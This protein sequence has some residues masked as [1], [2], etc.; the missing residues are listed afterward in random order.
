MSDKGRSRS[1]SQRCQHPRRH[2]RL[3]ARSGSSLY[4]ANLSLRELIF[5]LLGAGPLDLVVQG[6]ALERSS[7]LDAVDLPVPPVIV[8]VPSNG[9]DGESLP[10][11]GVKIL[12]LLESPQEHVPCAVPAP[13]IISKV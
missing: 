4:S 10:D 11:Q 1:T 12:S 6:S 3:S 13:L 2:G 8:N 9:L 7:T 5:E